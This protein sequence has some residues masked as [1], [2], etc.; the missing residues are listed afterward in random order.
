MRPPTN[1]DSSRGIGRGLLRWGTCRRCAGAAALVCSL[2]ASSL[3]A[4]KARPGEYEVKAAYLLNFG[5]FLSWPSPAPG[6]AA[7]TS[8]PICVLGQDPFGPVLET[9]FAGEQ[10]GGV[11]V[12]ARRLRKAQDAAGCRI[13]FISATEDTRLSSILQTLGAAPVLTVS[14]MPDFALRGGII[15]FVLEQDRVRFS[16]NL[17]AAENAGLTLSSQLLKVASSIRRE[18][19]I[20]NRH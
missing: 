17:A 18:A 3:A 8:F 2:L 13:L 9:T 10:I 14:D 4:D 20:R 11:D 19:L 1:S 5:K 15:Q 6:G 16:V 7:A 12:V